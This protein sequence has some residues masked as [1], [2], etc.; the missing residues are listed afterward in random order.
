MLADEWLNDAEWRDVIQFGN[1][2][3]YADLKHVSVFKVD[4]V[5]VVLRCRFWIKPVSPWTEEFKLFSHHAE[6][7]FLMPLLEK[8]HTV[9]VV[10]SSPEN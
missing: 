10:L 4:D 8:V 1:S 3:R 2:Y 9:Y 5:T 6:P 7:L